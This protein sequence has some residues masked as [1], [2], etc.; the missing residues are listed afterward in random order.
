M[1]KLNKLIEEELNSG[2]QI[3]HSYFCSNKPL[4]DKDIEDIFKYEA[5]ELLR[6]YFFDNTSKLEEAL[7]LL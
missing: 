6:E 3:G 2:H 4:S 5:E 7:R 1:N